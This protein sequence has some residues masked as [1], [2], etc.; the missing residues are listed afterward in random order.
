M[1]V[2][3]MMMKSGNGVGLLPRQIYLGQAARART[4]Q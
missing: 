2:M 4:D 1:C 3:M